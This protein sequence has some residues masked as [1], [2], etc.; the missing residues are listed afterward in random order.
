[1]T[2]REVVYLLAMALVVVA[3]F[4]FAPTCH[5]CEPQRQRNHSR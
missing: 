5:T 2:R 1:M 4:V 3:M